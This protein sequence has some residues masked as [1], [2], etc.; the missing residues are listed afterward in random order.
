[1]DSYL[2][3]IKDLNNFH[4]KY[5]FLFPKKISNYEVY[6]KYDIFKRVLQFISL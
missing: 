2:Q 4:V 1:M 6:N 3:E 5:I